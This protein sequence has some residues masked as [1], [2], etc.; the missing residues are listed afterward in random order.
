[1]FGRE[2]NGMVVE[3][4][5]S[6]FRFTKAKTRRFLNMPILGAFWIFAGIVFRVST[7]SYRT[8]P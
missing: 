2:Q 6:L 5:K 7:E 3:F 1:M 4:W 8:Y